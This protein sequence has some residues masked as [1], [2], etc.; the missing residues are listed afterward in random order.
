MKCERIGIYPF[1]NDCNIFI[2]HS[3]LISPSYKVCE[4]ASLK[5]W[6]YA[7][8]NVTLYSEDYQIKSSPQEFEQ[9]VDSLFVPEFDVSE[10]VENII[11]NEIVNYIPKINKIMCYAKL[12]DNNLHRLKSECSSSGNCMLYYAYEADKTDDHKQYLKEDEVHLEQIDIPVIAVAGMWENT[13][14]FKTSLVLRDKLIKEG[15]KVTQVGSRKYCEL[16]GFHSFPDFMLDPEISE[17]KKPLLFNR[18][19]KKIAENE[20]PD[21]II[22]GVPGSIQSFSEKHTNHF[23]IL[24][25]LVFQSVL[26]DFLVMCTFY[27]NSSTEFLEEVFNL[28]K[29][30]LSGTV[31]VFHM[32]NL[33]F[34]MD[35]T[36]EK[37]LISTNK[38][39]LEMVER[40]I[41]EKFSESRLPVINIYE[42]NSGDKL[43]N[44]IIDKLSNDVKIMI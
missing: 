8:K 23:G 10:Q 29:Y 30:R 3:D 14:K 2:Q 17:N 42:K 33:F 9:T 19:I 35:E 43:Y 6:G 28:C 5:G 21:V 12:T 4:L 16:F 22:I 32:S 34:D 13:D 1:N 38:L 24:P 11:V 26:V 7:D 37:G 36:L 40:T 15:Y 27:E 39:P 20:N 41:Q 31:D 44:M 18:Y 25:Y